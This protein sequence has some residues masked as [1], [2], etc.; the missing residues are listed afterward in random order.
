[1]HGVSPAT[2]IARA[3]ESVHE[4]QAAVAMPRFSFTTS[5]TMLFAP[6]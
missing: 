6:E 2:V 1:M 5:F 4:V 3:F